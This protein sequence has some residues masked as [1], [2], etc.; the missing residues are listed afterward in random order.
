MHFKSIDFFL[1]SSWEEMRTH[2]GWF[3]VT[4]RKVLDLNEEAGG[5]RKEHNTP[6]PLPGVSYYF[7]LPS[8]QTVIEIL[9]LWS[10]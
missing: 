7:L 9:A 2:G 10:S 8:L 5:A 3:L 1:D 6:V 4:K